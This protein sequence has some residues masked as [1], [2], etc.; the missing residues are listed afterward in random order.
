MKARLRLGTSITTSRGAVR[1]APLPHKSTMMSRFGQRAAHVP[2]FTGPAVADVLKRRQSDA[3]ALDGVIFLPHGG[4][5]ADLVAHELVH[6]L[7][8]GPANDVRLD[9]S[10]LVAD[11]ARAPALAARSPA[12]SEAVAGTE[13]GASHLPEH[14]L[15]AGMVALR[16]TGALTDA[17]SPE[18][19]VTPAPPRAPETQATAPGASASE[20]PATEAGAG[21]ETGIAP[22]F[23]LPGLPDTTLDPAVAA[24]REAEAQA[25][26][27][28]LAAV[29]SPSA[30][31][32]AYA[33]MAP[34]VKARN[35]GTL[36]TRISEANVQSTAR[37]AAATPA[38]EAKISGSEGNMPSP[39]P[40]AL[41]GETAAGDL[42]VPDAPAIDVPAGPEQPVIVED[43]GYGRSIE[44]IF[45]SGADA[46]R[47]DEN[48]DSVST[49]NP[50]IEAQVSDR[51]DMPLEGANDPDRLSEETAARRGEAGTARGKAATAVVEGP[52][53]E[54]VVPRAIEH[55]A[56]MEEIAAP[57]LAGIAAAPEASE[58]QSLALPDEVVA[59]FDSATGAQM[60]ASAAT[61]RDE[62]QAAETQR[63]A[64]H[65]AAVAQAESDRQHAEEQ[66]DADQRREVGNSRTAI[67]TERQ[68][69]VEAQALAVA[70]VNAEAE[71][72]RND[73]RGQIDAQVSR[74]HEAINAEYDQAERDSA[75]EVNRGEREAEAERERKRR[76]SEDQSWWE[77]AVGFIKEAF[78]ALT[79]LVNRIFNAV[80]E[81]VTAIIDLA[82]RAVVALIEAASRALQALISA[83]G[84]L[85]K[86]LIDTLLGQI[87]PELAAALTRFIDAAVAMVNAA[88]D[89]VASALVAAV[90]AIAAALTSAVN[91]VLNVFQA[92]INTALSVAQAALTGDWG[93][94][95]RQ[96]LESVLRILGI[97]PEAFYRIIGQ[98][99]EAISIIVRD[100]LH[101]VGNL[102][103]AFIGGVQ[104]FAGNFLGHLRRG[105]VGWLTGA[106]GNIILPDEWT[107]WSV[108]DLVRQVLGLTW[109]FLRDRASRLIGPQNMARLDMAFT[110]IATV[111]AEGWQGLWQ[112]IEDQL[113]SLKDT[114]LGAISSFIQ[115]RV[116]LS[117]ITWLASLFN[118]VGAIVKLVM[119]IWNLYQFLSNQLQRLMGVAQAVL[120]MISSIAHD[121]ID[122]AKQRV[123]EVLGNLVPV[124]IDLLMSLLGVTGV[125]ARVRQ[126]IHDVRQAITNAVDRMLE[127]VL[128]TLGLRQGARAE[129]GQAGEGAAAAPGSAGQ[130]G[131][132]VRINVAHG[133]YHTLTIDRSGAGGA[134]VMLR[135]AP[136]PVA[137]WLTRFSELANGEGIAADTRTQALQDVAA[138]RAILGPLDQIAD[139]AAA[140][141]PPAAATPRAAAPVSG[142]A[143]TAALSAEAGQQE[144]QLGVILTRLFNAFEG[145]AGEFAS[146][147][148]QQLDATHADA[149]N[150]LTLELRRNAARYAQAT[151]WDAVTVLLKQNHGTLQQPFLASSAAFPTMARETAGEA[152]KTYKAEL[153]DET[154]PGSKKRNLTEDRVL[155]VLAEG[156]R[157]GGPFAEL[158]GHVVNVIL[159]TNHATFDSIAE[160]LRRAIES[161]AETVAQRG[162]ERDEAL[163][164]AVTSAGGIIKFLTGIA[165]GRAGSLTEG[166]FEAFWTAKQAN[167]DYIKDRFRDAMPAQ[168]EWIPSNFII[169]IIQR[170]SRQRAGEEDTEAAALWVN[171]Q[172]EW[173]S[174]TDNLIF[175]PIGVRRREFTADVPLQDGTTERQ[176]MVVLQGHSGAVY[177]GAE[178]S[179]FTSRSV[180]QTKGQPQ[181]H[182]E[183]R[184]FFEASGSISESRA[185]VQSLM[186]RVTYFAAETVWEGS[187]ISGLELFDRYSS[188]T[189]SPV[190]FKSIEERASGA[191]DLIDADFQRA[192]KV[193]K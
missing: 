9:P 84:E 96:V 30:V 90:N 140:I 165:T 148:R 24:A 91:A 122:P 49:R 57:P 103:S 144:D 150:A 100:P 44:R 19:A 157:S 173:R 151:S 170:A 73:S 64:D 86:G 33:S 83:F 146:Q 162:N 7:Q 63:D 156:T 35:M 131:H 18:A 68:R 110:W 138:A 98:A 39:P 112:R 176:R 82:R 142:G 114:V 164:N 111:V 183:L 116:I 4:V 171:V 16:R 158:H 94:M 143:S 59:G 104:L 67:Q 108:L 79:R 115:E 130:I 5:P 65:A 23:S 99:S 102:V 52:G 128:V 12:E 185:S 133:E 105:I 126:I 43:P 190:S 10:R 62:M 120:G 177:A 175:R 141:P 118:P 178:D 168:H 69:T 34:S 50:G 152:F 153:V 145:T 92:A 66:A 129:R 137:G 169:N 149:R 87:F 76:E 184:S 147:F 85:L 71:A 106:L 41:P 53:P 161:A 56:P 123:E 46:E 31:M 97:E 186:R 8:Q 191:Y 72:A 37:L 93:A 182:D 15:P 26:E 70:D 193:I 55:S 3:A 60:E 160:H 167:V 172:H 17:A 25:A 181:W 163:V 124:A 166:E 54:Q 125:A 21:S 40:I 61:T 78:E 134:T 135:S 29:A 11:L 2:V 47:I 121:I 75:A 180:P 28:A 95:L 101:F 42:A 80:R 27:A 127:R 14:S 22:T 179:G 132:P 89:A 58:L 38:I 174:S 154:D 77:R 88:I 113:Q 109:D 192:L 81:A 1:A 48:I 155:R 36:G 51:A 20:A 119:T 159:G 136:L 13:A 139:R 32:D 74:D 107:I 187:S 6:A 188:A 45:A 189:G 117:A